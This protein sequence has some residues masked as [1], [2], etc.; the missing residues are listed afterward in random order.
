MRCVHW[1]SEVR[2]EVTM[3]AID[4]MRLKLTRIADTL[5]VA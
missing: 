2:N 1:S 4:T 5:S 3:I